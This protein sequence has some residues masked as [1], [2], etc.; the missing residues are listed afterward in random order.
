MNIFLVGLPGSGKS[1]L[2]RQLAKDLDFAF[3]DTDDEIVEREGRSIPDIFA[4]EG[5][6]YFRIL[7]AAVLKDICKRDKYIVATG[8]GTPCFFDNADIINSEGVSVF[9]NVSPEEIA[10]RMI[11]SGNKNRPMTQGK[12]HAELMQF[13]K[14]KYTERL[15]YYNK[16]RIV[17]TGDDIKLADIKAELSGKN[18]I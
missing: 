10:R 13:L 9:I 1:T 14:E 6:G 3:T 18:I 7:E 12:S 5:E 11:S 15:P 17:I 8:G 16:A 4:S 2:G